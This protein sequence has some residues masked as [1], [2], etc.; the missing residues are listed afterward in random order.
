[1]DDNILLSVLNST[2]EEWI[3]NNEYNIDSIG[4]NHEPKLLVGVLSYYN[5]KD[6]VPCAV[7]SITNICDSSIC[8]DTLTDKNGE[9]YICNIPSGCYKI[10]I[11]KCGCVL[12][13]T[14]IQ[15]FE[16][17]INWYNIYVKKCYLKDSEFLNIN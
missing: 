10:V 8:M 7:I 11:S 4:E 6:P 13:S 14:H 1:M 3:S 12:G 9:F 16:R 5:N 17:K 2:N 15:L